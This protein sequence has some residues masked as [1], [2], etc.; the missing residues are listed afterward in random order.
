MVGGPYGNALQAV[1]WVGNSPIVE[2]LL[3]AGADINAR[4]GGDCTALQIAAFAGNSRVLRSLLNLGV[5]I[6]IDAPGGK[7]G[8]AL[9]A[10]DDQGHFDAVMILLEAGATITLNTPTEIGSSNGAEDGSRELQYHVKSI[11]TNAILH[12]KWHFSSSYSVKMGAATRTQF[13]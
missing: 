13:Y 12:P 11:R 5:A 9:K 7:Y 3:G 10:R 4:G 2:A 8:C 6:N 1:A